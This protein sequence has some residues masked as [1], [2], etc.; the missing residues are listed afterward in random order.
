MKKRAI[1]MAVILTLPF[2]NSCEKDDEVLDSLNPN[3]EWTHSAKL[4][5]TTEQEKPGFVYFINRSNGDEF[6]G[7]NEAKFNVEFF[8]DLASVENISKIDFY[9]NA[10]ERIGDNF[11]Y[12]GGD[13][14]LLKTISN[15]SDLFELSFTKDEVFDI[16]KNQYSSGKT[17]IEPG[18]LFELRWTI[19]GKDGLVYDSRMDCDG[20]D[21]SYGFNA[22]EVIVDTWIGEFEYKWTEVGQGTIWYSHGGINVGSTGT[23]IFKPGAEEGQYDVVDM[24]FGG[25]YGGP[26]GG[27]LT[28]D[29][30]NNVLTIVSAESYYNSIW[31]AVSVTEEVL[32]LKWTNNF[33][34]RY[35]EFG[36]IEL[37]RSDGLTW[38][39][40]LTIVKL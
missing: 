21:C 4:S 37:R 36:T 11:K 14:I 32:T 22:K 34:T 40:G 16:F 12:L 7:Q 25:A 10:E 13:G 27:T 31:E 3:A 38:P 35:S 24:S 15:P 28:Y 23:A 9:I 19:T 5:F 17:D 8:S 33:T 30:T 26:R 1:W 20:F 39:V 29:V 2:L 6:W 18:D